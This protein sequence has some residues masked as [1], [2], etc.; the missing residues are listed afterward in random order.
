MR[1]RKVLQN[2][3]KKKLVEG[4]LGTFDKLMNEG[5]LPPQYTH[6]NTGWNYLNE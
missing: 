2:K 5:H 4:G 1:Q 3:H 6:P